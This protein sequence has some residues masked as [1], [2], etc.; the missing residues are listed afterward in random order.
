MPS[1][2]PVMMT[3]RPAIGLLPEAA[4][5]RQ[6]AEINDC[7][8]AA[9]TSTPPADWC[10]PGFGAI[11]PEVGDAGCRGTYDRHSGALMPSLIVVC[12]EN[13]LVTVRILQ[14]P[15][16]TVVKVCPNFRIGDTP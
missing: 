12:G 6:T 4:P 5:S 13:I 8:D 11:V 2:A 1:L 10:R 3:V 15:A 16:P 14:R 7:C 9:V